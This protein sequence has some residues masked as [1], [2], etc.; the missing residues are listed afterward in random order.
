[1]ISNEYNAIYASHKI[2]QHAK[3]IIPLADARKNKLPLNWEDYKIPKPKQTGIQVFRHYDL[4]E[5]AKYIDWSPFFRTWE[6][7]GKY[8]EI[9]NDNTVGSEA[10]KLF[11]DAHHMLEKIIAEEWLQA[12]AV[13]GIF[14]CAA[15]MDDIEVYD[16]QTGKYTFTLHYLR[17]QSKKAK[18]QYNIC[19]ADFIL[20]KDKMDLYGSPD[21][22]G[23]FAVTT[24]IGIEQKLKEFA[25]H[26]DDY[27]SIMLKALADR[28][29]EAFAE[30]M[31]EKVR[32]EYWGY[33]SDESLST[34]ALLDEKYTGI[35]PAPG[36]P[37]CP[38][39]TEKETLFALL[40][41]TG[42]TG[43]ALTESMAM[44]PASSV[45]GWYFAHPDS[46]YF[47]VGKIGEDQLNDLSK[48]KNMPLELIQKWLAPN[49]FV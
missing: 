21:Y 48:R 39:H 19:L 8:P 24:G 14:P 15:V 26:H 42:N 34:E 13:I 11:T 25:A 20:P 17:Q 36:Y 31:H 38:D 35:R 5:I 9:F 45:S 3:E 18:G 22:I 30:L 40:D 7:H 41:V 27:S 37:A 44:H 1:E 12:E 49:R 2:K 16:A 33:A 46:R 23:A 43:I 47:G 6:L 10:K 32:K 29:A 28:L 4:I